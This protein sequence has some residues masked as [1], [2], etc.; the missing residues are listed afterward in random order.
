MIEGGSSNETFL[1]EALET[2]VCLDR[3]CGAPIP[4]LSVATMSQTRVPI[5]VRIAGWPELIYTDRVPESPVIPAEVARMVREFRRRLQEQLGSELHDVRLF[6]SYARGTA[7][8]ASDVDVLVVLE[9]LDYRKQRNVL[10]IAGDLFVETNILLSP[11][12]FEIATYRKHVEQ[13]RPL[14]SEIEQQ[15][16]RI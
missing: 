15:G 16:L 6:G 3:P 4:S 14:A 1:L 9:R 5:P 2:D 10:D 12:V 7:H 8:E 11:T 13:R